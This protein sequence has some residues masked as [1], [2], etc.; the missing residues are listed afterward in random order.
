MSSRFLVII[1]LLATSLEVQAQTCNPKMTSKT[2]DSR[3]TVQAGGAEVLDTQTGLIWQRCS[4]GQSFS[5][6]TCVGSAGVYTWQS[7]LQAARN[8]GNGWRLPNVKELQSLVEEACAEPS[9]NIVLFPSTVSRNYLTSSQYVT[10]GEVESA[11]VVSFIEGV[12]IGDFKS[13]QNYVRVVRS[14]Q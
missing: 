1:S 5:G 14:S 2:P 6:N 9:I 10:A 11:W 4:L 12:S 13:D 3:Y 7:A 8:L